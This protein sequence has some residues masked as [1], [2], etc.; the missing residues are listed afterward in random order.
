M[1]YAPRP[2][3]VASP[4]YA[5]TAAG[6]QVLADGGSAVDAAIATAAVLCV[7]YPHMVS[8]G[9]DLW[10][11]MSDTDGSVTAVNGSGLAAAALDADTV[12]AA[13]NEVMPT[14]GPHTI[15]VPGAVRAWADLHAQ[16]GVLPWERLF[17]AAIRLAEEGAPIA[18]ALDR[19]IVGLADHLRADAGMRATFFH[20]DGSPKRA[21]TVLTQPALAATLKAIATDG[22]GALYGGSVGQA[23]VAGLQALGSKLEVADLEAQTS[24]LSEPLSFDGGDVEVLTSPPN[25]Q[26]FVLGQLVHAR[27]G[28]DDWLSTADYPHLARLFAVSNRE[29]D[30]WLADPTVSPID[31][32]A[33][34]TGEHLAGMI[35]IADD[36]SASLDGPVPTRATGDTVAIVAMDAEGRAITLI[37]SIFYAFGAGVLEPATGIVSQNR[38]SS[39]SLDE[40]HPAFLRGGTRPPHTLLPVLLRRD[41]A[42]VAAVGTM[43]GRSQA[44]IQMQLINGVRQGTHPQDIVTAPRYVVGAF[45]PNNEEVVLVEN[46]LDQAAI[47]AFAPS[48]IPVLVTEAFDDRAGHSHILLRTDD[49][50]LVGTDP[51]ADGLSGEAASA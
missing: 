5:A 41:G 40:E 49:G 15:T 34:T 8:L 30:R 50:I 16:A 2:H 33:L 48:A 39:F 51:R 18:A 29:R 44:Q 10:A 27:A 23:Y 14:Y 43:G 1:T 3:A 37:Q 46:R 13:G 47:D 21:G 4:H 35:A 26:G 42:V 9:G 7:V 24:V 32:E 6:E 22:P 25:S 17:E 20:E 19:D 11:V 38:G 31:V 45:G 36:A 12:R 28:R